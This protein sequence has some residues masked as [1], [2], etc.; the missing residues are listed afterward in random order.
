MASETY[1]SS[2][3]AAR[4]NLT[5]PLKKKQKRGVTPVEEIAQMSL[6]VPEFE[7]FPLD[8]FRFRANTLPTKRISDLR[9]NRL[10]QEIERPLSAP[11][12]RSKKIPSRFLP[13]EAEKPQLAKSKSQPKRKREETP[14]IAIPPKF[15]DPKWISAEQLQ[16][17]FFLPLSKKGSFEDKVQFMHSYLSPYGLGRILC[18]PVDEAKKISFRLVL[19]QEK[20]LDSFALLPHS[21]GGAADYY[22]IT[23]YENT[24]SFE[25][26]P[27]VAKIIISPT[28]E[29]AELSWISKG[30]A[31][32]GNDVFTWVQKFFE[33]LKLKTILLYDDANE[34]VLG[35]YKKNRKLPIRFLKALS[36]KEAL[37]WYQKR[38]GFTVA[39]CKNYPIQLVDEKGVK[40]P[41]E[42]NQTPE[43]YL[44][45]TDLIRKTP[46]K[47]LKGY[48][49][50]WKNSIKLIDAWVLK[51]LQS[52]KK[53]WTI[54][55]L[56]RAM[57]QEMLK[58]DSKTQNSIKNDIIDF[59]EHVINQQWEMKPPTEDYLEFE[60][61]RMIFYSTRLFVK[62]NKI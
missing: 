55:D 18:F 49:V 21:F 44:W 62:E 45:A 52:E 37:S 28:G 46:L 57:Q 10:P 8:G 22:Y 24:P 14:V 48:F 7:A 13:E 54:N 51:Y 20:V 4:S 36:E 23:L 58:N 31:L 34:L 40:T 16:E 39:P 56:L 32:S 17:E 9:K 61:A 6:K 33:L 42:L 15:D 29:I 26:D 47:K 35:P 1:F 50:N 5:P 38:G 41:S 43:E 60:K 59:F 19:N 30:N 25:V 27:L 12:E 11:P 3:A 53:K 2:I